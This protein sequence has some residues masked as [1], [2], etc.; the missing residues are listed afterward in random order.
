MHVP[1]HYKYSEDHEWAHAEGQRVTIGITDFAQDEL[2]EIVFVE[3]PEVGV[4]LEAG[5]PYGSL[6]S[7]KTVSELYAPI[8]GKVVAVNTSLIDKP[9]KVN[10]SPYEDG[11]MIVVEI[12]D[13]SEFEQL[14]S[15]EKYQSTYGSE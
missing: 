10:T 6:E 13:A 8:S 12:A 1:Q 9:E 2:G 5:Q 3:L 14:W 15:A 4:M 11:W 7:V